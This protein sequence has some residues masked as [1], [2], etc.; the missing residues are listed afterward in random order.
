MEGLGLACESTGV[1]PILIR[2]AASATIGPAP[3]ALCEARLVLVFMLA[4]SFAAQLS[5]LKDS[6]RFM[7]RPDEDTAA[8]HNPRLAF[9]CVRGEPLVRWPPKDGQPKPMLQEAVAR[10]DGSPA[11]NGR[12]ARSNATQLLL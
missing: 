5:E 6:E 2:C 12:T 7:L 1:A 4:L 3:T 10:R 9:A 11:A 8:E